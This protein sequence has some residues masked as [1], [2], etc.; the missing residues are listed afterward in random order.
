[1]EQFGFFPDLLMELIL[2]ANLLFPGN[3][4]GDVA[5]LVDIAELTQIVVIPVPR[6]LFDLWKPFA[7]LS[8]F[9]AGAEP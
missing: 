5:H 7:R 1:V 6:S 9:H 2:N 4:E 3:P 8:T